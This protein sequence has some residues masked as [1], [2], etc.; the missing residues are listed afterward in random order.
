MEQVYD[1]YSWVNGA[2]FMSINDTPHLC[3]YDA[4]TNNIILA[5]IYKDTPMLKF[6]I[7]G[8]MDAFWTKGNIIEYID[9]NDLSK[10][11]TIS[12]DKYNAHKWTLG[13]YTIPRLFNDSFFI[14]SIYLSKVTALKNNE[15]LIPY[16]VR[17]ET[18]NLLDTFA[19]IYLKEENGVLKDH[20]LFKN[21]SMLME[22]YEYLRFPI[23]AYDSINETLFYT[24]HK[25]DRLYAYSFKDHA[26]KSKKL[27][28]LVTKKFD[29]KPNDLTFLRKYLK[30]NDKIERIVVTPKGSIYLFITN[31]SH[32]KSKSTI[33]V[34]NDHLV[35][36]AELKLKEQLDPSIAFIRNEKVYIYKSSSHHQFYAFD[37][38]P[39]HDG[40]PKE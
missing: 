15:L 25:G 27:D 35:K 22:E 33:I 29:A 2:D 7:A 39:V 10:V 4:A 14:A 19:Y 21:P 40:L 30:D 26:T 17:N 12:I 20:K 37:L 23:C 3:V 6:P 38:S 18:P 13:A 32:S 28:P 31:N 11:H 36:I 8:E 16:R 9:K 34:Y 5:N 1:D 24:F